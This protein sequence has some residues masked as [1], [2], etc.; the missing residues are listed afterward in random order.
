MKTGP[1]TSPTSPAITLHQKGDISRMLAAGGERFQ[2]M[3]GFD[4]Q[5]TDIVDYI[6]KITHEIWEEGAIGRIYDY[7]S[8]NCPVHTAEGTVYGREA[9]VAGTAAALAAFPDRRLYGD[10]VIWGG[11]D[12]I[13]FYS[14][15]RL[16]HMGRNTG[17]SSF[18]PP[19]GRQVRYNAIAD[20]VV[21]ENRIVEEWLVRD[22]VTLVR[23]LGFDPLALAKEL[24]ERETAAGISFEIPGEIERVAGQSTPIELPPRPDQFDIEDFIRRS[25]HQIWN[26][27]LL[28]V[29]DEAYA[30]I[31]SGK[32]P[33]GRNVYGWGDYKAYV[34][35]LLA[36]FPDAMMQIDHFCALADGPNAYRTASRWTLQGTHLG[37]GIYGNPTGKHISILGM[38]HHLVRD[39]RIV[40]EWTVYDEFAL[41]KKIFNTND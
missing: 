23:Q 15:H 5:F 4:E 41:L 26:W 10:E 3:N 21:R 39:G 19:T 7:Y 25:T 27:R 13:G 30:P 20:C 24:A 14:S 40:Q 9:A 18:G 22:N 31:Y 36:A 1:T 37:P 35:A 32:L 17:Y 6:I 8:H 11:D 12:E 28:N 33:S 34:L 38:S 2:S 16:T 29:V